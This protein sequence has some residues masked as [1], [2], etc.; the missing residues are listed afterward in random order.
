MVG[1]IYILISPSGKKY[2]GQT[3]QPIHKRFKR[4][5]SKSSSCVAIREAIQKHGW[6]AFEKHYFEVVDDWDLDYIELILVEE[7]DSLVP[8][9][10]NLKEG[11]GSHGKASEETKRKISEAQIGEKIGIMG[12]QKRKHTKKPSVSQ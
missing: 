1:K 9:G 3:T 8:N 12:N 5:Q 11:G 2:A 7:L 6:D 10:Y 4:H